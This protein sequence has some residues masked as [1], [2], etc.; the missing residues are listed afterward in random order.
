[1]T[2][3]LASTVDC[4]RL[5]YYVLNYSSCEYILCVS[6]FMVTA[7]FWFTYSGFGFSVHAVYLWFYYIGLVL[8]WSLYMWCVLLYCTVLIRYILP[9]VFHTILDACCSHNSQVVQ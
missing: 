5:C 6:T 2:I 7:V 4:V 8:C 9:V 1:M 3:G